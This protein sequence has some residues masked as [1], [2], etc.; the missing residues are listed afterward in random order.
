MM[1]MSSWSVPC[2]LSPFGVSTPVIEK[3]HTFDP[4]TWPTGFVRAEN[5][6]R[7]GVADDADL[8]RAAHILLGKDARR[9]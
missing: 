5:L 1:T 4:Q 9:R 2:G 3:G 7:G 8:V 6:G